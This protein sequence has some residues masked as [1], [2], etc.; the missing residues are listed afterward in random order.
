MACTSR[1]NFLR[2]AALL[3]AAVLPPP[4]AGQIMTVRGPLPPEKLGLTLPHEHLM[5]MFGEPAAERASYD[6]EKLFA[7][8]VPYLVSLRQLGCRAIADC[9]TAYFGRDPALLRELSEKSG[10]HVLTNTGYYGAANDRYIPS[11]AH[12]ETA[13]QLAQRWVREWREGI[14]GTGIRPGFMKL[15]VDAGPL[16]EIDRKLVVAA[17]RAHLASGLVIAVHTGNN[18]VAAEQQLAILKAEGVSPAAWIW[19]HAHSVKDEAAL[20]QAAKE[21]AWLEFDGL[22]PD[23]VNRH[24]ELARLMKENGFLERVLISHDGNS[25]RAGGQPP[26]PYDALFKVFIPAL[27]SAGFT[28]QEIRQLT[29]EN[30][31]RAFTV[32]ARKAGS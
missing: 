11:H 19:V 22:D 8:V 15:G 26:K 25:F 7:A 13:G 24:L 23:S 30:P 28:E 3:P 18:P 10:L 31:R 16:S 17:A 29:V 9:T 21:G 20:L 6:R 4:P 14:D 32:Q 27:K 12:K 5:S 1:R 2:N